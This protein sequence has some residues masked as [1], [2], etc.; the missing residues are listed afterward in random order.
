MAGPPTSL[1][2]PVMVP[3]FVA[4]LGALVVDV[5][6][7]S[8]ESSPGLQPPRAATDATVRSGSKATELR[9]LRRTP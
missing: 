5:A 2:C 1:T 6:E 7:D 4:P 3:V 8:V 9:W